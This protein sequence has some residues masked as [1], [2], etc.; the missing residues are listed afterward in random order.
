MNLELYF[1]INRLLSGGQTKQAV[2][3]LIDHRSM[4]L[5]VLLIRAFFV[6]LC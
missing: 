5:A 6:V 3:G 4:D 2:M 1:S